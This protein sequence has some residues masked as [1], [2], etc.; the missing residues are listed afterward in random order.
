MVI[1][2]VAISTLSDYTAMVMGVLRLLLLTVWA[3]QHG[4]NVI[5]SQLQLHAA[6]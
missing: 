4:I 6:F 3:V 1:V 2:P 5:A